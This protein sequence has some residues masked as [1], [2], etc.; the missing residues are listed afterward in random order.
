MK[1]I[2][3]IP[4]LCVAAWKN[5]IRKYEQISDSCSIHHNAYIIWLCSAV[6]VFQSLCL[7]SVWMNEND[8]EKKKTQKNQ[9]KKR[10]SL[11]MATSQ[12][13]WNFHISVL[14]SKTS[15]RTDFRLLG[16]VAVLALWQQQ[17]QIKFFMKCMREIELQWQWQCR[18]CVHSYQRSP[19]VMVLM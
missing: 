9:V 15:K 1:A 11:F 3:E 12:W 16:G 5:L 2:A 6:D 4:V 8:E 7:S 19:L 10:T 13:I 17:S 14:T 18:W